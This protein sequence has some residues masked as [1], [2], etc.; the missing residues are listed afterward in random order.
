MAKGHKAPVTLRAVIARI[1]RKLDGLK[2]KVARGEI[3]RRESDYFL[4]HLTHNTITPL[5]KDIESYAR[6]VG[7]LKEWEEIE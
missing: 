3:V 6:E 4:L 2:L 5:K 7:A 1:N